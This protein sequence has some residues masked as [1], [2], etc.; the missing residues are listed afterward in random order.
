M[1]KIFTDPEIK[2]IKLDGADVICASPVGTIDDG[3]VIDIGDA[4]V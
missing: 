2:I 1:K 3:D 4:E